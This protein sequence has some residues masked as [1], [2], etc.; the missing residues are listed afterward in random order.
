M[1]EAR[2]VAV[3]GASQRPG[4]L[5]QAMMIELQRGFGGD[6]FPV[7]PRY[8]EI[9]GL[10]CYPSIADVP[11]PVDLVLLGVANARQEE[12]LRYAAEAG[13]RSAVTFASLY[14]T[15]SAGVPSLPERMASIARAAGM[16]ICGGNGMG[17][18]NVE[19][20]LRATGFALPERL[21][22]GNV[23]FIS[24]SGSAFSAMAYN[25]RDLRFNLLI[26]AGQELTT[27]AS[28]YMAYALGLE[29]TRAIGLLIETIRDADAFRAGL[30]IAAEGDVPVIALKVGRTAVSKRLVT[31]HSG[32]LAGE[33]GAYEALFDAYGVHRVKTLDEMADTL[34]LF[35]AGRRAPAGGLASIHDSG[36][37]RALF[38]DV[39]SDVGVRFAEIS[40]ATTMRLA[41]TLDE[42]LEPVNPLDAWGTGIDADEI[43]LGSMEA[44][45]DDG[46][47]AA[48]AFV[49]DLTKE[50]ESDGGY[51][52]VAKTAFH[53]TRKPFAIVSN[54]AAAIDPEDAA[55]LR[56]DGIPV[57]EGTDTG[58]AAIRHL[59]DHRDFRSR[60]SP[61]PP[62]GPG[63]EVRDRWRARLGTGESVDEYEALQLLAEY[64]IP[65]VA[66]ERASSETDAT[67]AAHRLRWPVAVKT[68]VPGI[69]HKSDADG[70]KLNVGTPELMKVAYRDLVHRLGAE[71]IV[72]EMGPAGVELALGIVRDAQFGPLVL[73]AAG[74]VLVE[75]LSDRA[76]ALPPLDVS[77]AAQLLDGLAMRPLLDGV[78]GEPAADVDSVVRAVAALSVLASDLGD[79]LDAVDVNPL[80]AAPEGCVA[81]DALVIPRATAE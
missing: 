12:Q 27:T 68:A 60:P 44:L 10:R 47:T 77:R 17:F 79:V 64:D 75:I 58:L 76:L 52:D 61:T 49:V 26:S 80:I 19:R 81:V 43:F 32:A 48:L 8:E 51:V 57:L 36:G 3:V 45:V 29:S 63:D 53:R 50:E 73:V 72:A 54:L 34:E 69:Q 24:H 71:V 35:V 22:P 33:D 28:D 1:L 56:A 5:G 11:G 6:I 42:G 7:N 40:D 65:V 13:V 70:V 66:A 23:A 25:R 21:D 4:T 38:L 14:E 16:V 9:S 55:V 15:P 62:S 18:V 41:D 30:T 46:D 78:R 59:F 31:A 20:G 2:S 39:A 74:G 37:E 67:R